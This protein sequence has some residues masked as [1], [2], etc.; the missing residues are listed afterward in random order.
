LLIIFFATCY[1]IDLDESEGD[2]IHSPGSV[3][4]LLENYS[5][6]KEE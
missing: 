5:L 4:R 1:V 2:Q 6:C 3:A